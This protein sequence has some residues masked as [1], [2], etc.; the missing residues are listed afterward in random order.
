MSARGVSLLTSIGLAA[1]CLSGPSPDSVRPVAGWPYAG[2]DPGNARWSALRE[3]HRDNVD[4]L[5]VVWSYRHG[6]Y[7]DPG[8]RRGPDDRSGTAFEGSPILVD[9]RLVFA[10]PYARV[11]ALD[12]ET[13]EEQWVFDPGVDR[14]RHYSNGYVTRGV[15]HWRAEPGDAPCASRIVHATVDA[16]LIELDVASGEPC[17]DFGDAG[18]LD[19]HV[20]VDGLK[21][22]EHYK[23]TS[24]PVVIGDLIVIGPSLA[25]M[26]PDQPAGDVRAFDARSGALR[27][28]FHVI[29]REDEIGSETWEH[30]SWRFGVGANPW[31]PISAD[32]ERGLLFVPTSTAS[33]DYYGG[34]RPGDNWFADSIVVLRAET[35]ERVWHRQL[36]HHDL[37]DYDVASPPNLLRVRREG[38]SVDAVAQL[39]KMGL[40][41]LFE[42]AT[43][44]PL[45]A[46]EER[47]VAA[48]EVPGEQASPTQP[49]PLRPPPLVHPMV[50]TENDLWERDPAHLEACR[51]LFRSLRYEGLFTPPS[52]QGSLQHPGT[53]GGANWS[54]AALDPDRSILYAPINGFAMTARVDPTPIGEAGPGALPALRK[55]H[56]GVFSVG[57]APC[58]KPPWGELVA[59]DMQHGD[60]LWRQPV[61]EDNRLNERGVFNLGPPLA[62]AGGL[63]FHGGTEDSALRAHDARTGEILASLDLPASTHAGPITYRIRPGGPQYLVVAAG[64]HH[65]VGRLNRSSQLGDWIIAYALPAGVANAAI[66]R[67]T[68]AV[69]ERPGQPNH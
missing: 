57:M 55:G 2:G 34:R 1:A 66:G 16:R 38:R 9:G 65:N 12:P 10:T 15:A 63:V 3:I 51:K 28:T 59:V 25:D 27:W 4:Q 58:T 46:I 23:L 39:T 68:A 54:G 64:G 17:R 62:T 33:P 6:D 48:S 5:E 61:G 20:G 45:F 7:Y 30:E 22:P 31:A 19:L 14:N 53:A 18:T 40:V 52:V 43:G 35:G 13:G 50:I 11:I 67:S 60:I 21:R 8:P 36:I 44:T 56:G 26:R 32:L 24:A 37:W 41:F 69:H 49:F 42:R 47:P 29:P